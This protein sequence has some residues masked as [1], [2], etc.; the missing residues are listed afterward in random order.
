MIK[1]LKHL[2]WKG[3]IKHFLIGKSAWLEKPKNYNLVIAFMLAIMLPYFHGSSLIACLLVLCM[4]AVFSNNRL[5]YLLLAIVSVISS[6][7]QTNLFS[8]GA[9][10]VVNFAWRLGFVVEKVTFYEVV[11]YCVLLTG[12]AL[13]L[14]LLYV[15]WRRKDK[16]PIVLFISAWVPF[17]FTFLFQ[18]TTEITANH[19]FIQFSLILF[20]VLIAGFMADLFVRKL[21]FIPKSS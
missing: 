11:K 21:S 3:K 20:D 13:Y 8:S 16:L 19:K 9:K 10:N 4:F 2:K 5:S 7:L 6:V 12:V 17:V 18:V 15:I 14:A 1:K